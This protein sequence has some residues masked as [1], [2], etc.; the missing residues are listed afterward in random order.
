MFSD[1]NSIVIELNQKT[2]TCST[3]RGTSQDVS[4]QIQIPT[5]TNNCSLF[6]MTPMTWRSYHSENNYYV[7]HQMSLSNG[8][9][10]SQPNSQAHTFAELDTILATQSQAQ[11]I[12]PPNYNPTFMAKMIPTP[13]EKNW[14]A[15]IV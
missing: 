10:C 4:I 9:I 3:Q 5:A 14:R 13:N 12:H 8:F 15:K 1:N 2:E 7:E 11:Q 6:H